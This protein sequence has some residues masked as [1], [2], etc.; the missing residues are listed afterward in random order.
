M[1][2]YQHLTPSQS[3]FKPTIGSR[4]FGCEWLGG[5]Q[6]IKGNTAEARCSSLASTFIEVEQ[7]IIE[8]KRNVRVTGVEGHKTNYVKKQRVGTTCK[9]RSTQH[10]TIQIH[11]LAQ[12]PYRADLQLN[13][14]SPGQL[15][16][17]MPPDWFLNWISNNLGSS[18]HAQR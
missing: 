12:P 5:H 7:T 11:K 13:A 9:S 16:N 4:L 15:L 17:G 1:S 10:E 3:S 8:K 2:Q 18:R 14:W 6:L